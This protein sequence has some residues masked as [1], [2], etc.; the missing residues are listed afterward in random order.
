[1]HL[2]GWNYI[3]PGVYF[4]QCAT[5]S[6]YYRAAAATIMTTQFDTPSNGL[7]VISRKPVLDSMKGWNYTCLGSQS[8]LTSKCQ[9]YPDSNRNQLLFEKHIVAL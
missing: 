6:F 5:L 8:L 1:M 9:S 3:I 7:G 2:I 4:L